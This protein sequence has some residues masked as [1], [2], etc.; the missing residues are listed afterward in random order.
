[1]LGRANL[2][3]RPTGSPV[4]DAVDLLATQLPRDE[5]SQA[6]ALMLLALIERAR[7]TDDDTRRAI[8]ELR[9]GWRAMAG[10]VVRHLG[11]PETA[12]EVEAERLAL[13]L[14]ASLAAVCDPTHCTDRPR[15]IEILQQHVTKLRLSAAGARAR[16]R[17]A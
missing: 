15:A 3:F 9:D 4:Q 8:R 16:A 12:Q 6:N 14:E 13:L 10:H 11:V 1:M 17:P 5:E 2:G 7:S